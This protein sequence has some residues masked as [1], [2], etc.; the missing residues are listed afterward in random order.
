MSNNK[1]QQYSIEIN[2]FTINSI[3][4]DESC[5]TVT[6]KNDD[7][8]KAPPGFENVARS[9]V[10]VL[11]NRRLSWDTTKDKIVNG[12]SKFLDKNRR[13]VCKEKN[14][15]NEKTNNLHYELFN[16][17]YLFDVEE[18]YNYERK[19]FLP[20]FTFE[21]VFEYDIPIFNEQLLE[22][23]DSQSDCTNITTKYVK[24]LLSNQLNKE[25]KSH[26]RWLKNLWK[27]RT[28]TLPC[29][30]S[31]L[32][33]PYIRNLTMSQTNPVLNGSLRRL[34]HLKFTS[35]VRDMV[36]FQT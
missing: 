27:I 6:I 16:N 31:N 22:G 35:F 33:K 29:P 20:D 13:I 14:Q 19:K 24:P 5:L 17:N 2:N 21:E 30:K 8:K 7:K 4:Y 10:N 32:G 1:N 15:N 25:V 18:T 12:P 36:K 3:F 9:N 28:Q 26:K 23:R 11:D 34:K